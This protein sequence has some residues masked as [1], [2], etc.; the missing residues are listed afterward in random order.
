MTKKY[1]DT[2]LVNSDQ[3]ID[4]PKTHNP[5]KFQMVFRIVEVQTRVTLHQR[6]VQLLSAQSCV[7]FRT[8]GAG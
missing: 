1:E 5:S 3:N 6:G 7:M 2:Q 8:R 4:D